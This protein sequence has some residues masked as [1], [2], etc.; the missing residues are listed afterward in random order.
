MSARSRQAR[1]RANTL[2]DKEPGT[3]RWINQNFLSDDVF[4]DIGANI[5]IY[6]FYA[7]SKMGASGSIYAIEPHALNFSVLLETITVND[8]ECDI[9]PISTALG[10]TAGHQDFVYNGMEIGSSGHQLQESPTHDRADGA[11]IVEKKSITTLDSLIEVGVMPPPTLL[12][13]DVDGNEL[14]I[15]EGMKQLLLSARRPRSMQIEVDPLVKSPTLV[16]MNECGYAIDH[17]HY[18]RTGQQRIDDG[19]DP[20]T[21]PHNIVFRPKR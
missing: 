8:F 18:T 11:G 10:K 15:L 2:A 19:L 20:E 3:I 12:K 4:C 17:I 6:T 5:G 7:A 9:Y 21:Y 16:L 13:L 1:R 14:N